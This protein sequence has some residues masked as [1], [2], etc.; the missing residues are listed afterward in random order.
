MIQV[1]D[2]VVFPLQLCTNCEKSILI[3]HTRGLEFHLSL[4]KKPEDQ[5]HNTQSR[6]IGLE[7]ARLGF[8]V[9]AEGTTKVLRIVSS[10]IAIRVK[11][12]N[13]RKMLRTEE[14]DP[15]TPERSTQDILVDQ[16]LAL[17]RCQLSTPINIKPV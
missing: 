8:E 2:Y 7:S 13:I 9:Y 5:K 11:V 6:L 12:L 16:T 10:L 1:C 14:E 15:N 17:P 4:E 3:K